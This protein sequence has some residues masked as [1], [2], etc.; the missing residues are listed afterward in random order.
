MAFA[1]RALI[2]GGRRDG[3]GVVARS[4]SERA[5]SGGSDTSVLGMGLGRVC[6]AYMVAGVRPW[7]ELCCACMPGVLAVAIAL[8]GATA[9]AAGLTRL[10][11]CGW[12]WAWGAASTP[13]R[14]SHGVTRVG[15]PLLPP[16]GCV[17][18]PK[19]TAAIDT[20]PSVVDGRA[21][22]RAG[23]MTLYEATFRGPRVAS[24]C[25]W[26]SCAGS[27]GEVASG[28]MGIC[29]GDVESCDADDSHAGLLAG[30]GGGISGGAA[31]PGPTAVLRGAPL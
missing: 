18:A 13:R 31:A 9:G 11:A 1:R 23:R 7:F 20:T 8:R 30:G 10:I 27:D 28:D 6:D 25:G 12:P 29:G 4:A 21:W 16:S 14:G 15:A 22:V 3:R 26:G 5:S 17:P 2:T 24:P 19:S